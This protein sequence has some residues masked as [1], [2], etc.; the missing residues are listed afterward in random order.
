MHGFRFWYENPGVF[1][2][3]Q[4][5]QIKQTTLGRVICDSSDDILEV[6]K[7]VF[8]LPGL[9]TPNYVSC[10][11]I[12]KVDLRLWSDCCHGINNLNY[13]VLLNLNTSL[14]SSLKQI[15]AAEASS[16]ASLADQSVH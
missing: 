16:I 15:V 6:T 3:E 9:Q 4:L 7:D 8:R 14:T 12:P 11:E 2:P 1:K 13:K 10:N 5:T